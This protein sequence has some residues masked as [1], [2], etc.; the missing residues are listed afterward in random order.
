M[1]RLL[2]ALALAALVF[3]AMAVLALPVSAKEGVVARVLTPIERD[4]TTGTKVVVVWRLYHVEDGKRISFNA[5]AVFIR[6]FGPDDARSRRVYASQVEPGRYRARVGVPRGGVRRIVIGLMGT[7]CDQ[8]G[9]R[10][11]PR[12]FPIVGK[13]FR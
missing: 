7:M 13:L 9:C 8:N 10:P 1:N 6:L 2:G 5:G 4:V 3:V 11:S 12:L